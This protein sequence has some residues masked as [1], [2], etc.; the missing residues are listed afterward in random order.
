[1]AH[2]NDTAVAR[3]ATVGRSSNKR[4]WLQQSIVRGN[5][6]GKTMLPTD[7]EL[8]KKDDDHKFT[9]AR[10]SS[11][12][13]I[14][15]WRRRRTLLVILG[16]ILVY[17]LF[18]RRSEQFMGWNERA[19]FGF[20][21]DT[22]SGYSPYNRGG[23]ENGEPSGPPP[24]IQQPGKEEDRPHTYDGQIRFYRLARTLRLS[25]A[26]TDGYD[27]S[28][29][30]VLFAISSLKSASTLL[31][32]ICEMSTWSRNFVHA[33]F[34]GRENIPLDDILEINGIDQDK[35]PAVWH[36]SRPDYSE[37]SS[38][39]RAEAA[40]MGALTHIEKYLHPQAL[41]VDGSTSEDGFLVRGMRNKTGVLDI[42]LIEVPKNKVDD[43]SWMNRLDAGSLKSWHRPLITILIQVTPDSS[44]VLRLL[45][46]IQE[47]D[48]SGMQFPRIILE[49]PAHL[50]EAVKQRLEHFKW[51]PHDTSRN[52]LIIRRRIPSSR[53]SQ[54][55]SATRFL[56]LFY[57]HILQDSHVLLLSAQA[58]LSPRYFHYIKY[59]LLEYRYS[60]FGKDDGANL[61]G[62]SLDSPTVLL[63]GKAKLET[64]QIIDMHAE[65]YKEMYPTTDG[66][67]F[68]W[69][70]PNSHA[71]L[72]YGDKWSE[73]HS[74]LRNRI[75]KH[76]HSP[77]VSPRPK[78]VSETYPSWMEYMLEFMRA[79]NYSLLYPAATSEALVT[80]H[81]EL[82]HPPEEFLPELSKASGSKS[83]QEVLDEPF[84][85]AD[86]IP[87]APKYPEPPIISDSQPL[88]KVLPFNG[89]L[90]EIPHLPQLT[91]DGTKIDNITEV[92][93][94][95]A[96]KFREEI[97][98]CKA[99]EGMHRKVVRGDTR[100]LFC[101]GDEGPEDWE[102][103]TADETELLDDTA[104]DR[105]DAESSSAVLVA[106]HTPTKTRAREISDPTASPGLI[107]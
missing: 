82:Y 92:A 38:D 104:K 32:M 18:P 69:Q 47:A 4:G 95:Y 63:D 49:L 28:N 91:W 30:N 56:E 59:A 96:N 66:S 6:L 35:C 46:S 2:R 13:G 61:M 9:P 23:F 89:D 10:Q 107:R 60:A 73:L 106:S 44:S 76:E 11:W 21:P 50:D 94:Q 68:L 31:P 97:G 55:E 79:R 29:R 5:M 36:D 101:F 45:R 54:V 12:V 37:Y 64:P 7:E 52:D 34:M 99:I 17:F 41:L 1:M 77:K 25:A 80:I 90:P 103:D 39:T 22:Y 78:L 88:D 74:F 93:T 19:Q 70:A 84:L 48:Y 83:P 43:L 75:T 16:I 53:A 81:N 33:A 20:D 57:P 51:P 42:A 105:M 40:A 87:A 24:G 86:E 26:H 98:G 102:S 27:S 15:R 100:D 72:F 8:G 14:L 85:R 58:Q 71:T 65:R 67:P 62:L 3:M